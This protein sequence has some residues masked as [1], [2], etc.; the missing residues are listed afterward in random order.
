MGFQDRDYY[1]KA[2]S[3]GPLAD[4]GFYWIPPGVRFLIIANVVVFLLQ[5]F[6]MVT[7]HDSHLNELRQEYPELDRLLKERGDDPKT[8]ESL[9][10]EYPQVRQL[11]DANED[12][13]RVSL[14]QEWFELDPNKVVH[15]GQVWRLVTNAFCHDRHSIW[16]IFFN[17]LFL[18]WFGCTL[19]SMYGTREFLLFYFAAA[20]IASLAYIGVDLAN[21]TSIPSIGASGAVMAVTMLYALHFPFE[22]ICIMWFLSVPMW[23][24]MAFYVLWDLHPVL[25]QLSGEHVGSGIAHAAH[26]GGLAFGFL[27]GWFQW[28]LDPLLSWIPGI[29]KSSRPRPARYVDRTTSRSLG[30]DPE[31]EHVDD[32]LRKISEQGQDSLTDEERAI[33]AN[34][35]ARMK[36]R[37]GN[38]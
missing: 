4:W 31:M 25:L 17:M 8:I 30:P 9:K 11:L 27:Y 37:R 28:R 23:L 1:R 10:R 12:V 20:I 13:R 29:G 24:L 22:T 32:I 19:E 2:N 33:L 3:S 15:Q 36:R 38:P 6:V 14:V 35:S 16:H 21:G 18:Y 5:M 7:V 34:A 26:I